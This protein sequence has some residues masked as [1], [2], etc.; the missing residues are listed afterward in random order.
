MFDI[1]EHTCHHPNC[2]AYGTRV[3][4][5]NCMT[6]CTHYINIVHGNSCA[7]CD[8]YDIINSMCLT[9]EGGY[10]IFDPYVRRGCKSFVCNKDVVQNEEVNVVQK[11]RELRLK[12]RKLML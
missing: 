5:V 10:N 3:A 2:P 6:N 8:N 4:Y 9:I 1:A 7:C 11:E 12:P